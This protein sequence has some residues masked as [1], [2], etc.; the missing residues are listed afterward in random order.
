MSE[1]ITNIAGY[2]FAAIDNTAKVF[3]S[4]QSI[5]SHTHIKGNI[6]IS[7]EGINLG[8][9]S[10]QSDIDYFLQKLDHLQTNMHLC[11]RL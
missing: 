11:D 8:L 4:V 3:E 10:T 9:A 7:P 5:C 6:F 2:E 1:R